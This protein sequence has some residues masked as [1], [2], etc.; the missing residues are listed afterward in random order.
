MRPSTFLGGGG[1]I[2]HNYRKEQISL[3]EFESLA[4]LVSH[5]DINQS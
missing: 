3:G 1:F 2:N 4:K 5:T